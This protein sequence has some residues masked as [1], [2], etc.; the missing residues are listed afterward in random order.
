MRTSFAP[1][2]FFLS[3]ALVAYILPDCSFSVPAVTLYPYFRALPDGQ[4]RS[5]PFFSA[6]LSTMM[7]VEPL[8]LILS[9]Y[10]HMLVTV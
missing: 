5:S 3:I 1:V 2:T 4:A 6:E 9:R 8:A 10:S 7:K